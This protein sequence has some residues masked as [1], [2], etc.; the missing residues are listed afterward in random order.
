MIN[1]VITTYGELNSITQA[2]D[3]FLKQLPK[4]AKIVVVDPFEK[5][6]KLIEEKYKKKVEFFLDIGE[7]K[8]TALNLVLE[9]YYSKDKD[10]IFIFSDGDV[11]VEE[12]TIR[13]LLDQFKDKK[14]GL[15]CGHPVGLNKLDNM[16]G[17]W[18]NL[19]FS[20][21]NKTRRELAK[22]K[23]FFE[24]SGYLFAMRNGV[25]RYFPTEA[26]EDNV[27]PTLFWKKGY[28]IGYSEDAIVYVKS[29]EKISEWIMQKK[30]NI[31]GHLALKDQ[32][33]TLKS[34][35]N[36]IFGEALRG[37]KFLFSYPNNLKEF[38][39]YIGMA[40]GRLYAWIL[41]IYET[42]VRRKKYTDGWREEE[43]L[44]TTRL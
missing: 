17:F 38:Y 41:A 29:P 30:R 13:E 25:I 2:V 3:A 21:M 35:K 9:N 4:N 40:L 8:S 18:G 26:S 37:I 44:T 22:K 43:D 20:E 31:K 15:V 5:T 16:L 42:K 28:K 12:N 6:R 7:G 1:I 10:D 11:F 24:V 34:R 32:V 19:A 27:I 39:W 36:T 14:I 23:E 33:D